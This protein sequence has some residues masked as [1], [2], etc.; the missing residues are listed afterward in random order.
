MQY[1]VN[2]VYSRYFTLESQEELKKTDIYMLAY[3][4]K[5]S[6]HIY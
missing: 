2:V 1:I 3:F 4:L 5:L 6:L